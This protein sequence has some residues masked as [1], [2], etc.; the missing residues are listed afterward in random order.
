MAN[1]ID[2]FPMISMSL[3]PL[4]SKQTTEIEA[5]PGV[6]G[7]YIWLT[8]NRGEPFDV[9]TVVDTD[10]AIFSTELIRQYEQLIGLPVPV[11]YANTWLE[12]LYAVLNVRPVPE[13]VREIALGV[14]GTSATGISYGICAAQWTLIATDQDYGS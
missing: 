6:D 5:R 1:F 9:L 10:G 11:M 13:M 3:N 7:T 14:G 2:T 4:G 8:G 12:K